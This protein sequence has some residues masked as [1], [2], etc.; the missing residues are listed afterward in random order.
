MNDPRR[1]ALYYAPGEDTEWARFG[2]QWF[3]N[4]DEAPRRYG[5]HA[6]LK[7]PFRL[8]RGASLEGLLEELGRYCAGQRT[9]PMPPLKIA[10]LGDFL[11]LIPEDADPRIDAVAAECV[12]RF[13]RF[14]APLDERDLAR[15]NPERLDADE[16]RL[17]H[18]WGY[19]QVLERF[20]FHLSLTGPLGETDPRR[21]AELTIEAGKAM[22]ILGRP[23]FDAICVFEEPQAG[24][25]FRLVQ[26]VPF[27]TPARKS[28][29]ASL[30][31]TRRH[32]HVISRI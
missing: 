29:R 10:L 18:R 13:D 7:A 24:G 12:I 11:A 22:D 14:R 8:A 30:G 17:L 15:R 27:A 31:T 1:Y 16:L 21:V 2:A 26:R 5:F 25:D 32:R 3:A 6:T 9:W 20:R 23:E 28:A 19:P 4:V